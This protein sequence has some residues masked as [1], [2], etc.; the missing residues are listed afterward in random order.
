MIN[1]IKSFFQ[2]GQLR[3]SL[4]LFEGWGTRS[5]SEFLP[6]SWRSAEVSRFPWW[7]WWSAP[8]TSVKRAVPGTCSRRWSSST[9]RPMATIASYKVSSTVVGFMTVAKCVSFPETLMSHFWG[10]GGTWQLLSIFHVGW[11]IWASVVPPHTKRG[12]WIL[13]LMCGRT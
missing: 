10:W 8:I 5:T 12:V 11:I 9:P 3:G 4:G 6:V 1:S 13:Q 2:R 7:W